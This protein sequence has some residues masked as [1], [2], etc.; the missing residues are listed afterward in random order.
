[1]INLALAALFLPLSHFGLSTG[2]LRGVLIGRMGTVAFTLAYSA[3][4]LAAFAWLIIA[5][6]HAPVV[7][8]WVAPVGVKVGLLPVLLVATFLAVAGLTTP[9]PSIVSLDGLLER[10][11]VVRGILRVTR[12]PFLWGAGLFALGHA[13]MAGHVSGV[14]AFGSVAFLALAGAPILD[15]KKARGHGRKWDAFAS[16]TSSIPFLAIVQGRQ[17]LVWREI[18]LWRSALA[19]GIFVAALLLHEA[20]FGG[21]PMGMLCALA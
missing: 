10:P 20:L 9:N 3:I 5:Y 18:G 7:V 19:V 11:D 21:D 14:L 1:M 4:T 2:S 12:N 13:I 16:Q 17:R 8:L 6:R 15:A